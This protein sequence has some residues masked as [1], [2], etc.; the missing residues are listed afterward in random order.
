MFVE[1]MKGYEIQISLVC[2]DFLSFGGARSCFRTPEGIFRKAPILRKFRS[3]GVRSARCKSLA[4][5]SD[6]RRAIERHLRRRGKAFL[7]L[8]EQPSM[9]LTERQ[10]AD[11][12]VDPRGEFPIKSSIGKSRLAP[13][14]RKAD[15]QDPA[16]SC[17][18][19][20]RRRRS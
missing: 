20:T 4:K 8:K 18:A 16:E 19:T 7:Y 14:K 13:K 1:F 11:R 9:L 3:K 10:I 2:H 17:H 15:F 6:P 12:D 5:S